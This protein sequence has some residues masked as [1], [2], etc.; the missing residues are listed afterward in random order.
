MVRSMGVCFVVV[1]LFA[2]TAQGQPPWDGG[3]PG[4]APGRVANPGYGHPRGYPYGK[5]G[6]LPGFIPG[7]VL[8]MG[9]IPFLLSPPAAVAPHGYPQP[10]ARGGSP[11]AYPTQE[12]PPH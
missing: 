3:R 9:L 12:T 1:L 4:Y 7:V 10:A 5:P 6:G 11:Q 8:G 2:T